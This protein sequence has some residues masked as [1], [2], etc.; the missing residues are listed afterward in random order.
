M[1]E[2]MQ[3]TPFGSGE[4]EL[5]RLENPASPVTEVLLHP[6]VLVGN[7]TPMSDSAVADNSSQPAAVPVNSSAQVSEPSQTRVRRVVK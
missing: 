4:I 7:G 5:E 3:R 2:Q 1:P 6:E